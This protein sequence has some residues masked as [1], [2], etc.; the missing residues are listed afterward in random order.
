MPRPATR[1][2]ALAAASAALAATAG[3]PLGAQTTH[4]GAGA[5]A[6]FTAAATT[7]VTNDLNSGGRPTASARSAPGR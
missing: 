4:F 6:A 1:R 5:R 3:A 7:P 2:L